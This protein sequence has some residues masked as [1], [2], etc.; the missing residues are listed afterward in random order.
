ME[1]SPRFFHRL[2]MQTAVGKSRSPTQD[3]SCL[4]RSVAT[5]LGHERSL[6]A[7]T[8]PVLGANAT[9]AT[10][11]KRAT[12]ELEALVRT[13]VLEGEAAGRAIGCGLLSGKND[14][15]SCPQPLDE[16]ARGTMQVSRSPASATFS[17]VTCPTA[18][19]FWRWQNLPLP[20]FEQRTL[21]LPEDDSHL[22]A[23]KSQLAAAVACAADRA[24]E[25]RPRRRREN[26]G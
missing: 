2:S 17:R 16:A 8:V 21:E 10:L 24:R 23:W 19:S 15:E 4:A 12:P 7:V 11:G 9:L 26:G 6:E 13:A 20:H 18:P 25:M 1:I 22:E 5:V 3:K 14:C